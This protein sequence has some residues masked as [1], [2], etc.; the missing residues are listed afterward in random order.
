[1]SLGSTLNKVNQFFLV[2]FA[3]VLRVGR[4][5]MHPESRGGLTNLLLRG[6]GQWLSGFSASSPA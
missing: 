2:T 1:M 4:W 3:Q 6:K 5:R